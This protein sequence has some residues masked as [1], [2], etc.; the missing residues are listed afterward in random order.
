MTPTLGLLTFEE[1]VDLA[2]AKRQRAHEPRKAGWDRLLSVARSLAG[3]GAADDDVAVGRTW[4]LAKVHIQGYQGVSATQPIEIEFDPTPGI[5]VLYGPNGSGKSSIADSIETALHGAPRQ[6]SVRGSGGRAPLWERQ[7]CGRDAEE[8]VVELALLSGDEQLALSCSVD[9]NDEV[10]GRR[11]THTSRAGST[12]VDL[13]TTT[14]Q[15]ALAG[16]RPVFGYASVERQVQLARNLQEFLEPLLAFGGCFETLKHEVEREGAPAIAARERW[17]AALA[18]SRRTVE[19]TDHERARPDAPYLPDMRWPDATEDPDQWLRDQGLT[20]GGESVP[21]VRLEQHGRLSALA[22]QADDAL[23]ALELAETSLHA[24]LAGPL[25]DLCDQATRLDDAGS[26]CP[27]CASPDVTWL[28]TLRASL[29]GLVTVDAEAKILRRAIGD[30]RTGV[31]TELPAVVTV[32]QQLPPEAAVAATRDAALARS[33]AFQEALEHEG[34]RPTPTVREATRA[35]CEYLTSK[36]WRVAVDEAVQHSDHQRQWLRARRAGVDPFVTIWREVADEARAAAEWERARTCVGDLQTQLRRDRASNLHL[37]TDDAVKD[38]L[39]DVG[40]S[41][42]ALS[43]QGT[44]A[45]VKV[46][47]AGGRELRLSMLSAGQRN[48]LLLAPLLAV[49]QGGPFGFLVLD[50]PVHAFDQVRVDRLAG[51]IERLAEQRRVIVLT[52]DERLREHLVARAAACEV[53]AVARD[54]LT[55]QVTAVPTDDL[56]RVLLNDARGALQVEQLQPD[57]VT[58]SPDD[59]VRNLC[60]MALDNAVRQFVLREAVKAGQNPDP[61]LIKLDGKNTTRDRLKVAMDLQPAGSSS[62]AAVQTA[63]H[64]VAPHL[65][66]WNRAAHGNA[67]ESVVGIAEVDAAE[68][69][70]AALLTP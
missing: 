59:L 62:R 39:A 30:L 14:W 61:D 33:V 7:H 52:H 41:V 35:L 3:S 47:D 1:L 16:H 10:T 20:E 8:A 65:S 23:S 36:D 46:V 26:T 21:E 55:G 48:A 37:L 68:R 69:A 31:A 12:E 54:R 44:K 51:V 2:E 18:D 15:S 24:R 64:Q 60:R 56:W 22:T 19:A 58:V 25:K 28:Q 42:T 49:S 40:V 66:D 4:S 43:V 57:G 50:D 45:D 53:R 13:E 67:P 34:Q 9:T 38:L 63:K 32:L 27:V 70:C 29:D 6:P 17:D 11:A 5:T